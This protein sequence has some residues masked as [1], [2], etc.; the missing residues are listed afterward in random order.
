MGF[1]INKGNE[2]F[3]Q[4]RHSEYVDKSYDTKTKQHTCQIE[5][6]RKE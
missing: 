3:R 5:P 4:I 6:W 2:G 1:Y